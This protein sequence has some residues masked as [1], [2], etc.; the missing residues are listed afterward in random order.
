MVWIKFDFLSLVSNDIFRQHTS[1]VTAEMI[2][3]TKEKYGSN[4]RFSNFN[5]ALSSIVAHS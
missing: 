5:H 1:G 4:L 2:K 3:E